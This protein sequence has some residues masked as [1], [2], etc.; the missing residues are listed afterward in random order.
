MEMR[1]NLE[2]TAQN[3]I[4]PSRMIATGGGSRS[5]AWLRIKANI[6]G[7]PVYPLKVKEAGICGCSVL[8]AATLLGEDVRD[9][10]ARFVRLDDPIEPNQS[11]KP[12][13]DEMFGKYREL[14]TAVKKFY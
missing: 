6:M 4:A 3:G 14:Y 11:V 10:A 12:L 1:L 8:S 5:G 9:V 13:Y 2:L 7:L